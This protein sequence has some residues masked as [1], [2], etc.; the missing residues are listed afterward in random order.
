MS[1]HGDHAARRARFIAE[2]A[3]DPNAE[4]AARRA[5]YATRSARQIGCW[6]LKQP[7]VAAALA[8]Q[9]DRRLGQSEA[10]AD[11][12]LREAARIAFA[13]MRRVFT[14]EGR[15]K[16][17]GEMDGDTAA[18]LRSITARQGRSGRVNRVRLASKVAALSML[19]RH[20]ALAGRRPR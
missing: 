20:L 7:D 10:I 16:E 19:C 12:V 8:A 1:R 3:R 15:L 13:D 5:G 2:F 11:R 9:E 17:L 14:P 4:R 18:A 6:L